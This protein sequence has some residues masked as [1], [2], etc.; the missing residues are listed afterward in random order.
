MD[1]GQYEA[2]KTSV[3]SLSRGRFQQ[4][5]LLFPAIRYILIVSCPGMELLSRDPVHLFSPGIRHYQIS[6]N[7]RRVARPYLLSI[8]HID[9]AFLHQVGDLHDPSDIHQIAKYHSI[10]CLIATLWITNNV[11][12]EF[13]S[14]WMII[15][16]SM[17][18]PAYLVSKSRKVS[19]SLMKLLTAL[20]SHGHDWF[21]R[22][23]QTDCEI[24]KVESYC[25]WLI[26]V[27]YSG[28]SSYIRDGDVYRNR[29]SQGNERRFLENRNE[30][31]T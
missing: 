2:L 20:G 17:M 16:F 10:I 30:F 9:V 15:Q 28:Q 25:A 1:P 21:V 24:F 19:T 31:P 27:L 29:C 12:S 7:S 23:C 6:Q 11:K 22:P 14:R 13:V 3:E 4:Q 5:P 8:S 26:Y 18:Y